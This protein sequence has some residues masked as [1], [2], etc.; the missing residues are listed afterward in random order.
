MAHRRSK[1]KY[2]PPY[3]SDRT[4]ASNR[5]D[6]NLPIPPPGFDPPATPIHPD[7]VLALCEAYLPQITSQPNYWEERIIPPDVPRFRL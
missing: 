3:K 2:E 7:D 1:P 5:L 4:G 6:L